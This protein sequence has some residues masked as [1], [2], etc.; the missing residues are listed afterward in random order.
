MKPLL[1]FQLNRPGSEPEMRS[2]ANTIVSGIEKGALIVDSTITILSFGKDGELNYC[3]P[4][5]P[6]EGDISI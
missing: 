2:L 5:E 4:Q 6:E 3:T 1:I